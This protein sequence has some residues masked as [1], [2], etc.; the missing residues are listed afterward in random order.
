M[1]ILSSTYIG[2]IFYWGVVARSKLCVVDEGEFFEKQ[3]F[4]NRVEIC[5]EKGRTPLI[6]PLQKGKNSKLPM[7]EVYISYNENWQALHLKTISSAY[8]KAAY[9][10]HYK[11]ELENIFSQRPQYL[12]EWNR[13]WF[14]FFSSEFEI[15]T[16]HVN[17]SPAY[18]EPSEDI[19]DYRKKMHTQEPSFF[20]HDA[21]YHVFFDKFPQPKN[22]SVLDLLMN[23]GPHGRSIILGSHFL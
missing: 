10:E 4:R 13:L 1:D 15:A 3:T 18:V 9:F 20:R 12:C 16:T 2:N 14:S 11:P 8:G 19:D 17:Y 23:E 22:L 5:S 21:Y 6:I 7:H